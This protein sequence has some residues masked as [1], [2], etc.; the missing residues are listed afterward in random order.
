M[1]VLKFL[2][3]EFQK[4]KS[5]SAINSYR[6]TLSTTIPPIDGFPVEKHPTVIQFMKG[7]YN[8]KP[9]VPKYSCVWDVSVVLKFLN[10]LQCNDNLSLKDLTY[11][12]AI[13]IALVSADR[14]QSIAFLDLNILKILPSKAVF[15][16]NKLTKTSRPGKPAKRVVLPTYTKCKKLCVTS[17]LQCYI[18]RTK[19]LRSSSILFISIFKPHKQVTSSTIARWIKSMLIRSGT[20]GYGAHSTRSASTSAALEVGLSVKD[21]INVADWSNASTFNKFYKKITVSSDVSF[22]KAI[23]KTS[24]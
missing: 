14:G 16:I 19:D 24:S 2:S 13:L 12:L 23:L 9:T 6:S 5:Y 11:K 10:S 18:E 8:L 1:D 17:T 21:I 4:N 7:V 15:V 3:C 20:S 22:G